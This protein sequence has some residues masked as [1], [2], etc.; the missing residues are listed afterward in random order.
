MKMT[1]ED[2]TAAIA[3]VSADQ[4]DA[5]LSMPARVDTLAASVAESRK[6]APQPEQ[7]AD[8]EKDSFDEYLSGCSE[9]TKK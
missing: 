1:I 3:N 2:F 8:P 7:T 4:L 9:F 6:P 5:I